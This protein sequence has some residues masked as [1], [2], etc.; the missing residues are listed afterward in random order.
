[1]GQGVCVGGGGLGALCCPG[2]K[3]AWEGQLSYL[4]HMLCGGC[5]GRREPGT[6]GEGRSGEGGVGG[7]VAGFVW[8]GQ[9]C[10]LVGNNKT[11]FGSL[12]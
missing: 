1:L 4:H 9:G 11:L 8:G 6:S 7:G 3:A 2:S 12:G 5:A 10:V